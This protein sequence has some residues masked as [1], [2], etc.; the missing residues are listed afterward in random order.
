MKTV[1][2]NNN[3]D[4][5]KILENMFDFEPEIITL[6]KMPKENLSLLQETHE[7]ITTIHV[8]DESRFNSRIFSL[9]SNINESNCQSNSG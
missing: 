1:E 5:H 2:A 4:M 3:D 9:L 6:G 8:E 7:I